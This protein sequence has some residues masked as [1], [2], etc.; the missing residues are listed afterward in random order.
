MGLVEF[1]QAHRDVVRD[2][3]GRPRD[4]DEVGRFDVE[5]GA[6]VGGADFEQ[7]DGVQ[8]EVFAAG[9]KLASVARLPRGDVG[10][11]RDARV[12]LRAR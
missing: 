11:G 10:V 6:G 2:E 1:R 12:F 5:A 7:F 9:A 8:F 3:V 4:V